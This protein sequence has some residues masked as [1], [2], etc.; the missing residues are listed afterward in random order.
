MFFS[1]ITKN[2]NQEILSK[3]F[4]I[5]KRWDGVKDE[6][7]Q[8]YSG[9]TEKEGVYEKSIYRGD[10]IRRGAWTGCRFK[11]GLGEKESGGVFEGN[12]DTPMHTVIN[13]N[14]Q[15]RNNLNPFLKVT[16]AKR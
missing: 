16:S 14:L 6:Q 4:V 13:H 1:V 12:V 2:L 3:N 7:I 11:R 9:F 5:F 10:Y 15:K 8:Y